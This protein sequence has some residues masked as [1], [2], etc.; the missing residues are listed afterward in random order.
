M[1]TLQLMGNKERK[2]LGKKSYGSIPHLRDSRRGPSDHSCNSGQERIACVKTRDD[3]DR[4][5][6]QEK[7]DGSN[8]AVLLLYDEVIPITRAGYRAF[9]SPYEMHHK[10]GKWVKSEE[11]R[12]RNLLYEGE[13]VCGE[14]LIQAHGTKYNLPHEPFVAFDLMVGTS[15]L[16]YD[17]FRERIG[18]EFTTPYL[19]S[20]GPPV[21]IS[22][23]LN[24]LGKFG[25]HGALEPVEGAVWR[26]ER[27]RLIDKS[28][29][30]AG[31][32]KAV[33]DFLV[34]YVKPTKIDGKYLDGTPVMNS[35]ETQKDKEQP[36]GSLTR[37]P[38]L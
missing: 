6:V 9:S 32:R 14:W 26:V 2:P 22:Q 5:I 12:F 28:R 37:P 17:L 16:T 1:P 38:R 34:K 11:K 33:V 30:N 7:L 24:M 19:L 21:R 23:A 18:N 8:V 27:N 35:W 4:V 13:R 3:H 36:N 10:F 20:D 29:G 25:H 15:R 31:G